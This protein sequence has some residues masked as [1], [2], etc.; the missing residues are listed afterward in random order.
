[1]DE[2][3]EGGLSTGRVEFST[4]SL[5]DTNIPRSGSVADSTVIQPSRNIEMQKAAAETNRMIAVFYQGAF[6]TKIDVEDWTA[7]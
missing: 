6:A 3:R 7:K 1:V 5:L 2:V 4:R